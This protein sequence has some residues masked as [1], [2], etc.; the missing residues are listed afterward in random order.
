MEKPFNC[1]LRVAW[2]MQALQIIFA[3]PFT[4]GSL[5]LFTSLLKGSLESLPWLAGFILLAYLG[6]ANALSTIHVTSEDVT[7][8]VFYGRF[9]INWNEVNK[10]EQYGAMVGLL[11]NEKRVVLSFAYGGQKAKEILEFINEQIAA[12]NIEFEK[13]VMPFPLT[14]K[15]SRVW[16]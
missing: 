7:V 13:D 1:T 3:L 12:R 14:H 11:G 6:W 4:A 2:W 15:N 10:I 16:R 5:I 8:T 9:R